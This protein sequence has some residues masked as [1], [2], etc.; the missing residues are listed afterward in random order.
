MITN[1]K[2]SAPAGMFSSFPSS[3]AYG[4]VL[5]NNMDDSSYFN[6]ENDISNELLS[7]PNTAAFIT[8]NAM[9]NFKDY[10]NCKVNHSNFTRLIN[11]L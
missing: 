7:K 2:G 9:R 11:S 3:S 1:G 4:K 10:K 6:S 5:S 8:E